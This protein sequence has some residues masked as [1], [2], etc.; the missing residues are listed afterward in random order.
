MNTVD[1]RD[2]NDFFAKL[3]ESYSQ[4]HEINAGGGGII[5]QGVHRRLNQKVVLKKI[6]SDKLN[7]IGNEREIQI[8]LD[9]KH[10]YLP[11]I[12]DFWSYEDEVYTVMEYI[13]GKSFQ[14]LLKE[15]MVFQEKDVIRWTRQLAEVLEYLHNSPGHVIHSDIK[16]AN[17]MLTPQNNICLIDFNV[18]ILG[19][20][21]DETIGYSNGY[22]PIEQ[23][24]G[25]TVQN[26]KRRLEK[27]LQA[28]SGT[29]ASGAQVFGGQVPS[30]MSASGS[31]AVGVGAAKQDEE[32]AIMEGQDDA[33]A[34]YDGADSDATAFYDGTDDDDTWT[35]HETASEPQS[36]DTR[37]G[38]G[39]S[40]FKRENSRTPGDGGQPALTL[41]EGADRM[42]KKYGTGLKVDERSDIY[43]ACATMYHIL[44]GRR[45]APCY[46]KQV[47]VEEL[48]PS[49]NDAFAH[50]LM[51]GMEQDPK[52]RFQD[53]AQFLNAMRQLV[54]STKRYKHLLWRQDLVLI[55]LLVLFL[56]SGGAAY[57]GWG[58]R[59][60]EQLTAGLEEASRLY[61]AGSYGEAQ[62][63]L[64]ANILENALYQ[65]SD[66]MGMA[67]YL[68]GN[69]CLEME[70]YGEAVSEYRKAIL[71]D[72]SQADYYRDYGIALVR[73]GNLDQ[74]REALLQA[75]A[76]GLSN[77]STLLLQGEIAGLEGDYAGAENYLETCLESSED[78][79]VKMHA[80]VKLD[81]ILEEGRG[82]E[83]YPDRIALLDR[84]RQDL[85]ADKRLIVLER[86]AQACGDY[87][88]L[89]GEEA[90]TLEAIDALEEVIGSG[91]GTLAE[92]L[93]EAVYYQSI[94]RFEE[95]KACL[96][97]AQNQYPDNYLIY[98]RLAF[99]EI[100]IQA[101]LDGDIRDYQEFQQYFDKC[102][103]LYQSEGPNKEQD[104]EMEYLYQ[105]YDEI[106]V[107]GWLSG[108]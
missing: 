30:G 98:K 64:D 106:V 49:V 108:R 72:S 56:G 58:M 38:S 21:S 40:S 13:E 55:L 92:Y 8:L 5:Y 4:I 32:T 79:Y 36:A 90:Y 86:L 45:P 83:A 85:P 19:G 78:V 20:G 52:K 15:G 34:F 16:P 23:L 87:G 71:L 102:D 46:E 10:T 51:H 74:A 100:D 47:P 81:Q 18:S 33:T 69:C 27:S 67:H 37:T 54:R 89:T 2:K 68:S 95:A 76:K 94:G 63:Y 6:R 14:D 44:T 91:Y 73:T 43:S 103:E 48:M 61:E 88:Q 28:S 53:A 93:D 59:T 1:Y 24:I 7:I 105:I 104:L 107:K 70:D 60:E 77:D 42:I 26:Q 11:R 97:K 9:L 50:I 80:Y 25:L 65:N 62:E 31:R 99:L 82:E 96:L 39:R 41:A 17:L 22:A 57:I 35:Y 84:A 101:A 3:N 29:A 66:Q 12:L 75:K